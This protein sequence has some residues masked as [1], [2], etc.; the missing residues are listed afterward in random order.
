MLA[1]FLALVVGDSGVCGQSAADFLGAGRRL[2]A[3][4]DLRGARDS[5]AAAATLA[6]GDASANLL[7]G[8]TKMLCLAEEPAGKAV[9]TRFG[10]AATNRGLCGWMVCLGEA[11]ASVASGELTPAM[12][13][14]ALGELSAGAVCLAR[15]GDTNFTLVLGSNE[16][17]TAAVT[18]DYAD[19]LILRS[20][21]ELGRYACYAVQG[22]GGDARAA[23]LRSLV[24]VGPLGVPLGERELQIL[25]DLPE[26]PDARAALL[27]L[28]SGVALY[29][30]GSDIVRG[31]ATNEVRLF[32]YDPRMADAEGRVRER[33]KILGRFM[34]AAARKRSGS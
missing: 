21:F 33:L 27:A 31:R 2:L 7:A 20:G 25:V 29:L 26:T 28:N 18:M 12:G 19:L 1:V 22:Q 5:F 17:A 4:N 13:A 32:N 15:I 8:A 30:T 9:L 14:K 16:T 10:L 23:A 24:A 11:A 34:D 3:T 6:P